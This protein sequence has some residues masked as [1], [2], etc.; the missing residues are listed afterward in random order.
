MPVFTNA[1]TTDRPG[2]R[3]SANAMP[4]GIPSKREISVAP[5]EILIESQVMDQTSVSPPNKSSMALVMP[6]QI[7]STAKLL[8]H[9][10][11]Y[12]Q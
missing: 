7:S 11:A 3:V 1:T 8:T 9:P 4:K 6:C 12:P 2:K 5:P 10:R